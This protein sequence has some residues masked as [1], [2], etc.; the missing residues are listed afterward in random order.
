MKQLLFFISFLFILS[1]TAAQE[2]VRKLDN[3]NELRVNGNIVVELLEGNSNTATVSIPTGELEDVQTFAEDGILRIK[4]KKNVN[5]SNRTATVKLTYKQLDVITANANGKIMAD[6]EM[7]GNELKVEASSNANINIK[8]NCSSLM[9]ECNSGAKVT[10][11]GKASSQRVEASAGG[12]YNA[13]K[14]IS[15]TTYIE[16]S[17]GASASVHA[18]KNITAEASTGANIKYA[19]NPTEKQIE[20]NKY[21]GGSVK[22]F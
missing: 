16:A 21:S 15:E 20:E 13:K 12:R 14:L 3:F 18:T 2:Q 1:S 9:V 7:T 5:S 10:I 17:S 6:H 22:G 4:W 8:A 19:G 11:S